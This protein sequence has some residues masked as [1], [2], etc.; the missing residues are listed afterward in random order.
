MHICL[1]CVCFSFSVLSQ[2]IGLKERLQNDLFCVEWD[3]KPQLSENG[4]RGGGCA[5][6]WVVFGAAVP[7]V[8]PIVS[9]KHSSNSE[10]AL[11]A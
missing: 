10:T 9:F 5:S 8:L 11:P 6:M 7:F 4:G 2:E 1:C 3:V